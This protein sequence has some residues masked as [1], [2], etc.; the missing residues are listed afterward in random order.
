V[1]ALSGK[2]LCKVLE[3]NGWI[4]QRVTGSHHIYSHPDGS[5]IVSVPVHANRA[6]KSGTQRKIMKTA[7]LTE[8]DL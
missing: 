6:L 1:K 3:R 7:G 4:K 5:A 8:D 2:D